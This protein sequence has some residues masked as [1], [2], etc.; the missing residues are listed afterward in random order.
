MNIRFDLGAGLVVNALRATL[1]KR[2]NSEPTLRGEGS[3]P[4]TNIDATIRSISIDWRLLLR[5][6][7][8]H[9]DGASAFD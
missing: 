3:L 1:N 5:A 8:N 7:S 2:T 6:D 4:D 9:N